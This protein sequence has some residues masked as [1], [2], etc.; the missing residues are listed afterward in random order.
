MH[1]VLHIAALM[2]FPCFHGKN[3]ENASYFLDDLEMAF[4]AS[5]RDQDEVKLRAFPLVMRDEAKL[6]FQGLAAEDRADWE[7]LKESFL[8][9]Y[10][11]DNTPEKLWH[12]LTY[13]QQDNLGSYAAYE[14]QFVKLWTE[15][16]A[17]LNEGERAP[18]F[19]Q[20]ERFLAGLN[21]LLQ[22]KVRAKFPETFKDAR[23]V[24]RAKDRKLQFQ[25][26]RARRELQPP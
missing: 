17:S 24:A 9:R 26:N 12:K 20:K 16:A 23:Q 14:A 8:M 3:Y 25:A 19:L 2:N 10:M 6:W 4:L 5:G 21:T 7:T 1:E 22:E 13:L 15:W 11:T 18:N